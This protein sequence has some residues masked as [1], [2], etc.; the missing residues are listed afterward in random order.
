MARIS[1][2]E[3]GHPEDLVPILGSERCAAPSTQ[4]LG[5]A[6]PNEV[7][8]VTICIRRRPDGAP[9]PDHRHFLAVHPGRSSRMSEAEFSFRYGGSLEDIEKVKAFVDG[10]GLEVLEIHSARR[11]IIV[12][13]DV[14]KMNA[15]FGVDLGRYELA[16][17]LASRGSQ[18]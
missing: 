18:R 11:T 10:R 14:A 8:T 1:S 2:S 4:R 7:F 16:S 13:G 15:A 3:V 6:D 9:V 12:K 17:L 5:P